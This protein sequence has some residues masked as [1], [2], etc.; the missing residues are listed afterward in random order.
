MTHCRIFID[1]S[2]SKANLIFEDDAE[3]MIFLL[4]GLVQVLHQNSN[5]FGEINVDFM[6]KVEKK[7]GSYSSADEYTLRKVLNIM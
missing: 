7:F 1:Q 3:Y 5:S 6:I 2:T 4:K